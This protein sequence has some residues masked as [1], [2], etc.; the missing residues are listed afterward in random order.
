MRKSRIQRH[1]DEVV[2]Q[3]VAII[4]PLKVIVFGSAVNGK[5]GPDSDI[6][7]LVVVPESQN[8]S[9]VTDRLYTDIRKKPMPCDF[10]VVTDASLKKNRRQPG[11]IYREIL[12]HG[13]EVYAI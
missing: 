5:P 2:A 9:R 1:I 8:P 3:V 12:K 7:F 10:L 6:D 11:L 13:K 4:Q